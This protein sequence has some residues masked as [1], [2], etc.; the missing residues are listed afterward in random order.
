[1]SYRYNTGS[2]N[3]NPAVEDV[4]SILNTRRMTVGICMAVDLWGTSDRHKRAQAS[5]PSMPPSIKHIRSS[6]SI[7]DDRELHYMKDLL[8]LSMRETKGE[9]IIWT[10]DDT[11]FT[12][13]GITPS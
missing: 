4:R 5:W 12:F 7:G 3:V 10:N 11:A 9:A 13:H 6:L 2:V 1:M 8:H